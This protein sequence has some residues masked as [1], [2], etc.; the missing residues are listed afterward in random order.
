VKEEEWMESTFHGV[1][2]MVIDIVKPTLYAPIMTAIKSQWWRHLV[3]TYEVKAG[4]V[5]LQCTF[6]FTFSSLNN[7]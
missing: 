3:N 7:I 6:T 2:D 5:C 4:M 1:I